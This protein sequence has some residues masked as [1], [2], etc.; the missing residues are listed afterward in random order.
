MNKVKQNISWLPGKQYDFNS[1]LE[2]LYLDAGVTPNDAFLT[3]G[4]KN[5]RQ[6]FGEVIDGFDTLAQ[7]AI[8]MAVGGGVG[9]LGKVER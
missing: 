3:A 2:E 6:G 9:L 7:A 4:I 5:M 1:G 8:P